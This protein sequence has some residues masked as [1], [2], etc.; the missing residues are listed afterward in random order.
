[1]C[2]KSTDLSNLRAERPVLDRA[3]VLD[4]PFQRQTSVFVTA[5]GER[6]QRWQEGLF[7]SLGM[8]M[9]IGV[10]KVTVSYRYDW[11]TE[12]R[13]ERAAIADSG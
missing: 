11:Q 3:T 9:F 12:G 7:R 5:Q 10:H 13:D 2:P 4:V 1:M 8:G 6:K